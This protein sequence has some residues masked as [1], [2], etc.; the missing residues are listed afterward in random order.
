[1]AEH[2]YGNFSF[3]PT[4][5]YSYPCPSPV[6]KQ[7][8]LNYT[9]RTLP[10]PFLLFLFYPLSHNCSLACCATT[11]AADEATNIKFEINKSK[12]FSR[13][14]DMRGKRGGRVVPRRVEAFGGDRLTGG[15]VSRPLEVKATPPG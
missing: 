8:A 1:M 11:V 15:V 6:T 4:S 10:S 14:D 9:T 13:S 5:L 3:L 7:D 2:K 12:Q